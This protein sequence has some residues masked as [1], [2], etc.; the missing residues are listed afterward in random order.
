MAVYCQT[1]PRVPES[2]PM[3]KQSIWTISPGWSTSMWRSGSGA[4]PRGSGGAA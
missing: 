2:R 1:V 3:Q 4:A